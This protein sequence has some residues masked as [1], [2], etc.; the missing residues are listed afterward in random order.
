MSFVIK[1]S[2]IAIKD[3]DQTYYEVFQSC[4]DNE[5]TKKYLNDLLSKIEEKTLFPNSGTPLN[6]GKI[7]TG[8]RYIVFKSYI[9]FYTITSNEIHVERILY[10]KSDYIKKLGLNIGEV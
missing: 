4:L 5:T 6:F 8:Y 7:F 3:I 2:S 9:I 10:A 1:Y